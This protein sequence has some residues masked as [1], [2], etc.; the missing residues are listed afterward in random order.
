MNDKKIKAFHLL[1]DL[2]SEREINSINSVSLI[3]DIAGVEY[4]QIVNIPYTS[5]PPTSTCTYPERI[6]MTP[7]KGNPGLIFTPGSYGCYL[8]HRHLIESI[9]PQKD[10]I[11]LFFESDAKLLK[12]P[13]IFINGVYWASFLMS[14]NGLD[15]FSLAQFFF[16]RK[17]NWQ[18]KSTH[19]ESDFITGTHCYLL[20]DSGVHLLQERFLRET[21]QTYDF[22]LSEQCGLKFGLFE[23]PL[24][25]VFEGLSLIDRNFD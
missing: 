20:L 19:I 11:Y 21:W 22:W 15:F 9:Q 10:E 4:T 24:C 13:K 23:D 7:V 18:K 3:G 12:S 5:P 2:Q 6:G 14:Q 17:T 8:A 25:G 1:T 16:H